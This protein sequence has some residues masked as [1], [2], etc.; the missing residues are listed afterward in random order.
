MVAMFAVALASGCGGGGNSAETK[1]PVAIG[2]VPSAV[3]SAAQKELK[4]VSFET[5]V[6]EKVQGA[7]AFELTGKD[8]TGKT[9]QVEVSRQGKILG[10]K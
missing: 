10:V 9:R 5:A 3:L 1:T 2:Q 6:K 8:K 7:D 4:G